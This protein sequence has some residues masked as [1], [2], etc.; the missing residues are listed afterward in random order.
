MHDPLKVVASR[1]NDTTGDY[2]GMLIDAGPGGAM[3]PASTVA[4]HTSAA[5]PPTNN[6]NSAP[7][8][9][10]SRGKPSAEQNAEAFE[11]V[12]DVVTAAYDA[13]KAAVVS[14]DDDVVEASEDY[15]DVLNDGGVVLLTAALIANGSIVHN[16]I[17]IGRNIKNLISAG[18]RASEPF[19]DDVDATLRQEQDAIQDGR[20]GEPNL[21]D[22]VV[23][24][25]E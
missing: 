9:Q 3:I 6:L 1:R 17:E 13:A 20:D 12:G 24:L 25:D 19:R 10:P 16:A 14:I 8:Q 5:P 15:S 7:M 4:E 21:E 2:N 22:D 23:P 18:Q 11:R